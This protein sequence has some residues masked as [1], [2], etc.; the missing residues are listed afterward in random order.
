MRVRKCQK[1]T[2]PAARH[3]AD[4]LIA[5]K[6]LTI[7]KIGTRLGVVP[8]AFSSNPWLAEVTLAYRGPGQP[9]LAIQRNSDLKNK[10][11]NQKKKTKNPP[12]QTTTTK[13][14][15]LLVRTK[16]EGRRNSQQLARKTPSALLGAESLAGKLKASTQWLL[17]SGKQVVFMA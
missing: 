10:T 13:P 16:Q 6:Q 7:K 12:N 15:R 8:H 2:Y 3:P 11:E 9:G 4:A 5:I 14:N 17:S 1:F